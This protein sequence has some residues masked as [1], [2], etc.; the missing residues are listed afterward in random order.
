MDHFKIVDTDPALSW[1]RETVIQA[2]SRDA[3]P[4]LS[5]LPYVME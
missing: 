3:A 2:E 5:P 1:S 4:P